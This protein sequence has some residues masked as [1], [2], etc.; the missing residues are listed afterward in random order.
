MNSVLEKLNLAFINSPN[1]EESG[2]RT[3]TYPS[4]GLCSRISQQQKD[5]KGIL[6]LAATS[7]SQG[8]EHHAQLEWKDVLEKKNILP[9]G[10]YPSD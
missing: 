7:L 3:N 4:P 2:V 1:S 6:K 9:L 10:L 5:L 8:Q